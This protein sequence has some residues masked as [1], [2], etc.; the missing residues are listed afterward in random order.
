MYQA[1]TK[2]K[3]CDKQSVHVQFWMTPAEFNHFTEL[4]KLFPETTYR[5]V[6]NNAVKLLLIRATKSST[7]D[8]AADVVTK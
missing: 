1:W 5:S 6:F 3:D 4:K 8:N 2:K 7:V